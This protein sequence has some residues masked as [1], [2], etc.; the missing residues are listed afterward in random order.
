MRT[1]SFQ[2]EKDIVRISLT[3]NIFADK[4]SKSLNIPLTKSLYLLNLNSVVG[5]K[6]T[7]FCEGKSKNKVFSNYLSDCSSK[8][9]Y[10]NFKLSKARILR[11]IKL[12]NLTLK[13]T[14]IFYL[15]ETNTSLEAKKQ[16]EFNFFQSKISNKKFLTEQKKEILELYKNN[17]GIVFFPNKYNVDNT[18][19]DLLLDS[20]NLKLKNDSK[21]N[22]KDKQEIIKMFLNRI[23]IEK[24]SEIFNISQR[25]FYN[26]LRINKVKTNL[27]KKYKN[28]KNR[29]ITEDDHKTIINLYKKGLGF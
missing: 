27:P 1:I 17:Y 16:F 29:L 7:D 22:E 6:K 12:R 20:Y 3:K 14:A 4:I 25:K 8:I 19:I 18:T 24:V 9:I 11:I 21:L 23:S 28:P 2:K 10:N 26:I 13:K 15:K 5:R